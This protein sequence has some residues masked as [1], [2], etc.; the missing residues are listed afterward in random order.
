MYMSLKKNEITVRIWPLD[1]FVCALLFELL[2]GMITVRHELCV[3]FGVLSKVLWKRRDEPVFCFV[4]T[5]EDP[6]AIIAHTALGFAFNDDGPSDGVIWIKRIRV[7]VEDSAEAT[8]QATSGM[9]AMNGR[10]QHTQQGSLE[11]GFWAKSHPTKVCWSHA[12]R[13]AMEACWPSCTCGDFSK[14]SV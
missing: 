8:F 7:G 1:L 11:V 9:F 14:T 13:W 12:L 4:K 2:D 10:H 6:D 3:L 5:V